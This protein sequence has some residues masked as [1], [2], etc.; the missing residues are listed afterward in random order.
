[1]VWPRAVA[2]SDNVVVLTSLD[3]LA[4]QVVVWIEAS[5]RRAAELVWLDV[6]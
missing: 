3:H 1:M 2:T 5:W 6:S 4:A